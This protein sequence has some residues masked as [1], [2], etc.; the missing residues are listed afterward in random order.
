M[1]FCLESLFATISYILGVRVGGDNTDKLCT[2]AHCIWAIWPM[3]FY[4]LP[5]NNVKRFIVCVLA[6]AE[7]WEGQKKR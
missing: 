4:C 1:G 7:V 6:K 3:L 2:V 5:E